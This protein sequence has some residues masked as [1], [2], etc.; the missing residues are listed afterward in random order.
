MKQIETN[1]SHVG[2]LLSPTQSAYARRQV[3]VTCFKKEQK[4]SENIV[5]NMSECR[6]LFADETIQ[7]LPF[8]VG[9]FLLPKRARML[10]VDMSYVHTHDLA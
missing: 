5:E 4:E 7:T 9:A 3:L 8:T 1:S 6:H 10:G 2:V